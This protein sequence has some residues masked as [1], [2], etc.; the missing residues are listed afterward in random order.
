MNQED[1]VRRTIKHAQWHKKNPE[2]LRS[3]YPGY[4]GCPLCEVF[5]CSKGCPMSTPKLQC[6]VD[7]SPHSL[8]LIRNPQPVRDKQPDRVIRACRRWLKKHGK[9]S[10]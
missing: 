8:F 4:T 3:D 1:A 10:T 5:S 2:A 9:E 6:D 7:T